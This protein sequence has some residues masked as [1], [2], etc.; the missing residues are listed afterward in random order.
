MR[1]GFNLL[2]WTTHVRDEH[3]PLFDRL[4]TTGYDGVEIPI[5][6]GDVGHYAALGKR[7]ADAGLAATS[8]TVM[9]PGRDSIAADPALR[10]GA[11]DHIRWAVDRSAALGSSL[12]CGPFH[13]PLGEFSGQGPTASEKSWCAE[14]HKAAARHAAAAGV[15]L[16][17]EP[18]N[19]FE[20]Y[21]LN[22][23]KDAAA[24]VAAVDEPNYG[25]LFDTFH[26]N[27]EE[28]SLPGAIRDT[29]GAF[30]HVHIS[31]NDR[32][33]PGAGHIDFAGVF[34]ALGGIGYDGWM[35]V[36]AF[37]QALPDLAAAT[38]IWRPLFD[39]P[40]E[41]YEGAYTLMRQGRDA[42]RRG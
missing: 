11:L 6:E 26:S 19:R 39:R 23:T 27:I 31:E 38:K 13:Q 35:T 7:L 34:A 24:L 3:A 30:N 8:V 4:K 5:F 22:T 36:E 37:G 33:T 14:T 40:E 9:P 18:L 2:L 1:L 28:K 20:C 12:L 21:F 29:A 16:S 25:Y 10:Q 15:A 32:G 17:I 42:A 41:V